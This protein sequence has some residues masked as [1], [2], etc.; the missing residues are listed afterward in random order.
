MIKIYNTLTRKKEEFKPINEGKVNMYVCGPTVYN[1]IHLGNARPI[2]VFD[3]IR[4]YLEYR[5]YEV[6]YIQNFTDVD[7][8]IINKANETGKTA[9]EIAEEYIKQYFSDATALGVRKADVHP[10]VTENMD[11]IIEFIVTLIDN[12]AAYI[13]DGDVYFKTTSFEEYG[14]LSK[15]SID[16]LLLGARVEVDNKKENPLDF[17]LWKSS[18][19]NEVYWESPWGQGRPGWHIEC[20][21]MAKKF[22][23]ESIDIH[24][25][26]ADLIF[27]HHE[28]EIAQSESLTNKTFAKY[29]IHNGYI[30]IDNEKMSK[31]LGNIF[32][33]KDLLDKYDSKVLRFLILSVHYRHPINFSEDLILQA[34]NSL[35]RIET[36]YMNISHRLLSAS[37]T[38]EAN[39]ELTQ[40]LHDLVERFDGEMDDDF[41]TANAITVIF[42]LI[43]K[44]NIYIQGEVVSKEELVSIKEVLSKW[45]NILGLDT[46]INNETGLEDEWIEEQIKERT[47]AKENK[48]WAKADEIREK[49]NNSGVIIEDTPQGVRW[50]KK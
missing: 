38:A 20:S 23:G 3:T 21:T 33:V 46:F 19:P 50:R 49:L 4:R 29:W 34:K 36:A 45:L 24:A 32:T 16:D 31:S 5:G 30:T 39:S 2:I 1:Y 35:D 22:L 14:K 15:Q 9:K 26:G 8:K 18:K 13:T 11:E 42:E 6:K 7:D 40:E 12:G 17:A 47:F 43:K 37:L 10:K 25:G 41:N 44:A 28:N 48:D 27:P